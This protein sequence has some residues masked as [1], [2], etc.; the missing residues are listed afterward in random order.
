M[1]VF[2]VKTLCFEIELSRPCH[3]SVVFFVFP[4]VGRQGICGRRLGY[5][6]IAMFLSVVHC[7]Q[8][9]TWFFEGKDRSYKKM[10]TLR[11]S[12]LILY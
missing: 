9:V 8:M 6:Y 1:V 5:P 12:V 10:S 3:V 7:H 11:P 2:S 4:K